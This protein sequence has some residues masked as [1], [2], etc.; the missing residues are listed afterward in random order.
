MGEKLKYFILL[1]KLFSAKVLIFLIKY[2]IINRENK[3]LYL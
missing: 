2:I 3:L 1:C